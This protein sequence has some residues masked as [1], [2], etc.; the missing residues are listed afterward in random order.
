MLLGDASCCSICWQ[1]DQADATRAGD[2]GLLSALL[3][4]GAMLTVCCCGL[5]D[6]L[7]VA[8]LCEVLLV[9]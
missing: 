7:T 9:R 6:G 8:K 4:L 2:G 3:G 1:A 5:S